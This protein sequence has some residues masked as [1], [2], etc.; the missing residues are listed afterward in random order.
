[1]FITHLVNLLNCGWWFSPRQT[2]RVF[3]WV[4]IF[5]YPEISFIFMN[6][7]T[8]FDSVQENDKRKT[9]L[10]SMNLTLLIEWLWTERQRQ[11]EYVYML[12]SFERL[13]YFPPFKYQNY[14]K[15][16]ILKSDIR[17]DTKERFF[18]VFTK[19]CLCRNSI[20][21]HSFIVFLHMF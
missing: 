15:N 9:I 20:S 19:D 2:V 21:F 8:R 16:Y 11:C 6:H 5:E 12:C 14:F 13:V 7:E 17:M 18:S 10:I 1:M 3:S 4:L